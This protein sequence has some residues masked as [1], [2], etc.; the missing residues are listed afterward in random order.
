[1]LAAS[2]NLTTLAPSITIPVKD[3][4]LICKIG[5]NSPASRPEFVDLSLNATGGIEQVT[6]VEGDS[7]MMQTA[8]TER[9]EMEMMEFH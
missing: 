8:T 6:M 1:L 4:E 2:S 9:E 3:L 7:E 5:K